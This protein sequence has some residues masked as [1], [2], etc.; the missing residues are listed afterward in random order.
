M[1]KHLANPKTSKVPAT[2][3]KKELRGRSCEKCV[4]PPEVENPCSFDLPSTTMG[5]GYPGLDHWT[6]SL[7][8]AAAMPGLALGKRGWIPLPRPGSSKALHATAWLPMRARFQVT[9][10][11]HG[12][13]GG[14]I[15]GAN[16]LDFG[17]KDL[18]NGE[19]KL[20]PDCSVVVLLRGGY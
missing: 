14:V 4:T 8:G 12:I 15:A 20:P 17:K 19:A 1:T 6:R 9:A 3:P 10:L 2:L 11:F 13:S 7:P 18:W 5:P 16:I